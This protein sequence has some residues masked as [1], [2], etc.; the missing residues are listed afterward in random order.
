M[1]FKKLSCGH[2]GSYIPLPFWVM[3]KLLLL[4]IIVALGTVAAKKIKATV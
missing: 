2:A 4:V 1:K 3:K